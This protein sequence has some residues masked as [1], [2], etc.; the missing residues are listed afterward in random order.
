MCRTLFACL[1]FLS[2]VPSM[3]PRGPSNRTQLKN[4]V[5]I[6]VTSANGESVPFHVE[7]L[8]GSLVRVGAD[9]RWYAASGGANRTPA[10]FRAFPQG[11]GLL[12]TSD[13]GQSLH[14][15]A[16]RMLGNTLHSSFFVTIRRPPRST[17][18][19]YTA[20]FRSSSR[21]AFEMGLPNQRLKLTPRAGVLNSF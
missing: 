19:P 11:P 1:A 5:E 13:Q 21:Y 6:R 12:F 9:G 2:F 3:T 15:E 16:W 8:G 17:L 14:V 20:L 7:V 4:P 10:Q 18:F